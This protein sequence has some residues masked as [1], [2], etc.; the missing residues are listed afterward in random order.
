VNEFSAILRE[1]WRRFWPNPVLW[2]LPVL[3][4]VGLILSM[5]FL[6]V[7]LARAGGFGALLILL[8]LWAYGAMSLGAL[9]GVWSSAARDGRA[10]TSEAGRGVSTLFWRMAGYLGLYFITALVIGLAAVLVFVPVFLGSMGTAGTLGSSVLSGGTSIW[11]QVAGFV[12]T[13]GLM[14]LFAFA[15]AAIGLENT[16]MLSGIGRGLGFV[17][18]RFGLALGL[19]LFGSV[20]HRVPSYFITLAFNRQFQGLVGYS[21][22][23]TLDTLSAAQV[24]ALMGRMYPLL[25]LLALYSLVAVSFIMLSFF[26]AYERHLQHSGEAGNSR[27]QAA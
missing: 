2:G 24:S 22:G 25:F 3:L 1:T 4:V 10:T 17:G 21:G 23:V 12:V 14:M 26:V 13:L 27:P 20:L 7:T 18:R 9:T 6:G 8:G 11:S 16:S 19:L 5:L 15:P